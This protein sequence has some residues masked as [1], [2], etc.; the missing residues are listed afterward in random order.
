M[1]KFDVFRPAAWRAVWLLLA[2]LVLAGCQSLPKGL[3]AQQIAV[4]QAH[5]FQSGDAGW[6]LDMSS[7]V[8][9]GSDESTLNATSRETVIRLGR[10]LVEVGIAQLRVDGHTDN[11]GSDAYNDALSLRR[12]EVV[13]QV[14]VEQ[15]GFLP[16]AIAVRGLGKRVPASNNRT[17]S[18]RAENR[19]VSIVVANQ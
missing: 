15:A 7:K 17:A 8:L 3:T 16:D 1:P 12:A 19:R 18:G 13:A 4:L 14:L 10:A 2:A 5:G 11:A 9:F 6:E